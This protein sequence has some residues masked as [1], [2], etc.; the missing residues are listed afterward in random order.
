MEVDWR[1][2]GKEYEGTFW[3]NVN[4]CI[5]IG[6]WAAQYVQ[7]LAYVNIGVFYCM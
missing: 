2:T 7:N 4:V 5:F 6:I 3:G 1:L